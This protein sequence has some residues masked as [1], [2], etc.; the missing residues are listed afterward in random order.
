MFVRH[1]RWTWLTLFALA[2]LTCW[3]GVAVIAGMAIGDGVDLGVEAL[4]REGQA[5]AI[6][7]WKQASQGVLAPSA[8]PAVVARV[9]SPAQSDGRR[10]TETATSGPSAMISSSA[11][12]ALPMGAEPVATPEVSGASAA[13]ATDSVFSGPTP[14]QPEAAL[15][16]S[17]L[18]LADP[19]IESLAWLDAEMARSALDRA[20][21]IRY[22]EEALNREIAALWTKNP[23]LP[24]R[25][26]R[27]DLQPSQV[28]VTGKTTVL[29]FGVNAR[30][31]GSVVAQDCLPHLQIETVSVVGVVAP[32]FIKEHFADMLLKAM[33][34]YPDDYPLCLE[35]IVMGE[36]QVTVYGHSR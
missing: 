5:T 17:P 28:V 27:V 2:N 21:Q 14:Q 33:A 11:P 7:V 22:Q 23:G 26:I 1:S 25:N 18:L 30:L 19:Q 24:F 29:G 36:T 34:W 20:V 32:A 12:L 31:T 4:L 13:P 6:A 9:S 10:S 3:I 15:V 16:S 35:Q 8:A